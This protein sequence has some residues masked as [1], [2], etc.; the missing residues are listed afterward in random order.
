M[1]S[2]FASIA[3]FSMVKNLPQYWHIVD[4]GAAES[5]SPKLAGR[6]VDLCAAGRNW[7]DWRTCDAEFFR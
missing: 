2:S 4:L 1:P 5:K 6:D 7:T 3:L